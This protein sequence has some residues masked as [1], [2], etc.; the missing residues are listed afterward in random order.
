MENLVKELEKLRKG[1]RTTKS[2]IPLT[3]SKSKSNMKYLY[4]ILYYIGWKIKI[5]SANRIIP[6]TPRPTDFI[7]HRA[8][9]QH[10]LGISRDLA[11]RLGSVLLLHLERSE[12]DRQSCLLYCTVSILFAYRALN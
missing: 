10:P 1:T 5:K 9:W 6:Q 4:Y 3:M 8:Y 2:I 7:R 11:S 12:M